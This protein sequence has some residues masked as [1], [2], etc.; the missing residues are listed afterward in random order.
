VVTDVIVGWHLWMSKYLVQKYHW[1]L[2]SEALLLKVSA[3]EVA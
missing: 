3:R 2:L 1:M